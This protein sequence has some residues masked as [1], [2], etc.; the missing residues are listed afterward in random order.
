MKQTRQIAGAILLVLGLVVATGVDVN[1]WQAPI[2]VA[3][4]LVGAA[5]MTGYG[6]WE[7]VRH[8][9][10]DEDGKSRYDSIRHYDGRRNYGQA[11][12]FIGTACL[13]MGT[14]QECDEMADDLWHYGQQVEVKTLTGEESFDIL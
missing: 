2:A 14:P 9:F 4:L 13:F 7:F 3:L 8:L 12:V 5:W 10:E 1:L 11:A 6:V